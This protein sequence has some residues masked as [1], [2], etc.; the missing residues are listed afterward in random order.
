M[1]VRLYVWRK[2]VKK[3]LICIWSHKEHRCYPT[4]WDEEGAKKMGI[5]YRPNYWHCHKCDPCGKILEIM[6]L[7]V[8]FEDE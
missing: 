4:V 5:K 8:P 3:W 2:L 6:G 1:K 7:V